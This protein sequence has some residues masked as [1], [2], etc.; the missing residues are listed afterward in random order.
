MPELCAHKPLHLGASVNLLHQK[1]SWDFLRSH[2]SASMQWLFLVHGDVPEAREEQIRVPPGAF[3]YSGL[4]YFWK[5][6]IILKIKACHQT[7]DLPCITTQCFLYGWTISSPC[8]NRQPNLCGEVVKQNV[9]AFMQVILFL[10]SVKR[11]NCLRLSFCW[12]HCRGWVVLGCEQI[13]TRV[14]QGKSAC[15]V[16]HPPAD[17]LYLVIW[18][19]LTLV[20]TT[21]LSA[22]RKGG[23][24]KANI[25]HTAPQHRDRSSWVDG[26]A[27]I[28]SQHRHSLYCNL[29]Q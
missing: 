8:L 7:G 19:C 24:T 11:C 26:G 4:K 5:K 29:E 20:D 13:R 6:N 16:L 28:F 2:L 22:A 9:E 17:K 23:E 1:F 12:L 14:K 15:V 21:A 3:L 18:G 25:A 10:E 27:F